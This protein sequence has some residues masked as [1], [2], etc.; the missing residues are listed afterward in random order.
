MLEPDY[1]ITLCTEDGKAK[2]ANT[3]ANTKYSQVQRNVINALDNYMSS[4]RQL[5]VR[6]T[7]TICLAHGN[8]MSGP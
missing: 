2:Y 8:Y 7:T 3:L 1:T 6:P 4:P 5:Y